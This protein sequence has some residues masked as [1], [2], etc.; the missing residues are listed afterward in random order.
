M[1]SSLTHPFSFKLWE[2]TQSASIFKPTLNFM[3]VP[4]RSMHDL[5]QSHCGASDSHSEAWRPEPGDS[6]SPTPCSLIN[7]CAQKQKE[8]KNRFVGKGRIIHSKL[9]L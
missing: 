4:W 7:M 9:P 1:K 3:Q 2:Q 6:I 5:G 8:E